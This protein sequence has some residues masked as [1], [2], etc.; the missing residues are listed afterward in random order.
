MKRFVAVLILI[1]VL[2]IGFGF[3]RGWFVLASER[4][5]ESGKVDVNLTVD[6]EKMKSDAGQ[7]SSTK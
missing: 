3:Y 1:A 5:S 6:P 2:G 7:A 4:H